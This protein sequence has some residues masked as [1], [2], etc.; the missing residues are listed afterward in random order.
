LEDAV[1]RFF[2]VQ[3]VFENGRHACVVSV[4]ET[5]TALSLA[6]CKL[7]VTVE[8]RPLSAEGAS[9]STTLS[10]EYI[11][12]LQLA[13]A[14]LAVPPHGDAS[15]VVFGVWAPDELRLLLGSSLASPQPRHSDHRLRKWIGGNV[16]VKEG[17]LDTHIGQWTLHVERLVAGEPVNGTLTL[18]NFAT[19][20]NVSLTL[21]DGTRWFSR[22]LSPR[23][24]VHATAHISHL[25]LPPPL[26]SPTALLSLRLVRPGEDVRTGP[27]LALLVL[28][29]AV[30]ATCVVLFVAMMRAES[31]PAE[32]APGQQR[33]FRGNDSFSQQQQQ[34]Q[35][36]G[37]SSPQQ[38]PAVGRLDNSMAR[39][40]TPPRRLPTTT[41]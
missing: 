34:Q 33:V 6:P 32:D 4:K 25:F 35:Q 19:G 37:V 22:L 20:Q 13:T 40:H 10:L 31:G 39:G 3:V 18:Q 7:A 9:V 14:E 27:S 29:V 24:R 41:A 8:A 15:L 1:A 30:G 17:H 21:K 36:Q 11:P 16:K 38:T 28:T 5:T 12:P 23:C 26:L 2:V